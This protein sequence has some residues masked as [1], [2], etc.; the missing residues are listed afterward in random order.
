[1]KQTYRPRPFVRVCLWL[2]LVLVVSGAWI[3]RSQEPAEQPDTL[4]ADDPRFT[5]LATVMEATDL[6]VLRLR[7]EPGARSAWHSH[8]HGQ[9]LF[10]EQ[11]RART[12]KRGQPMREMGV[13]ESDYTGPN[14]E[15]WHGAVPDE[16]FVQ[17]AVMWEGEVEWLERTTDEEY[18]G[19][20]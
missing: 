14:I 18:A 3:A 7:F 4:L 15:H 9:L 11:G 12:Q 6:V 13:G 20:E 8:S 5:G 1:M 16:P 10:V 2:A 19:K 17:I